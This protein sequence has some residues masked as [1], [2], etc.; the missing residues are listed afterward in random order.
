MH[1]LASI[2]EMPTR[3]GREAIG[4]LIAQIIGM[5]VALVT[6]VIKPDRRT[7]VLIGQCDRCAMNATLSC[8]LSRH[9]QTV[10]TSDTNF[11]DAAETLGHPARSMNK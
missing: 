3:R 2:F 9:V 11:G 7:G 8:A 1:A 4:M 6:E 5:G 10:V